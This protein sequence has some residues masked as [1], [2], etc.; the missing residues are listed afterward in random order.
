MAVFTNLSQDHLDFHGTMRAY[1][2]A[3]A[4]LFTDYLAPGGL[5]V[6]AVGDGYG[7]WM[8]DL[9]ASSRSDTRLI[10][11]TDIEEKNPFVSSVPHGQVDIEH[12]ELSLEGAEITLRIQAAEAGSAQHVTL[13]SPL[14]GRFNVH[15]VAIAATIMLATGTCSVEQVQR[16]LD[17]LVGVPGRLERVNPGAE[18]EPAVF[19][20]YAHT[21]DALE[22]ALVSLRPFC[23]GCLRVVFGCGGDRDHGKRGLMGQIA[24]EHADSVM[25]TSDNPRSERPERIIDEIL[26]GAF[27][28][29]NKRADVLAVESSRQRAIERVLLGATEQDVVLIA[30]KGHE[31]YQEFAHGRIGFDDRVHAASALQLRSGEFP[32]VGGSS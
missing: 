25:I 23:K 11:V 27:R 10:T 17:A 20:D 31:T 13:R 28:A 1:R 15:N 5:A 18:G 16:G 9:I 2:D 3:K 22:R 7:P 21:P 30:G 14:L 26:E 19:V 6:I 24:A 29:E 32:R 4:R 12:A 8:A